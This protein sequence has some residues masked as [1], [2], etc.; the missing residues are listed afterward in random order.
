VAHTRAEKCVQNLIR[1]PEVKKP[2]GR[3]RHEQED[4]IKVDL[5]ELE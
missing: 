4:L 2:P 3:H 5:K 1:N